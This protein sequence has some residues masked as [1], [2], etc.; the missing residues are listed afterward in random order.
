VTS[1]PDLPPASLRL[2]ID[3]DALAGNWRALNR[4]SGNAQA[5]A[6]V[7]ANAYGVGVDQ[8]MPALLKAGARSF[9]VAH[10]S[11][12]PPLLDHV[13][14]DALSVLH[15]I[16]NASEARFAQATGVRPVINSLHQA[17]IWAASGG[18]ACH[19]MIDT[20]INRLGIAP[21]EVADPVIGT[22]DIETVM[23]HLASAD[24]DTPLNA[25]QLALFHE[26]S[27]QV[28][29]QRRSLAN[30]AGIAL[31]A[32]YHFELTRPGLAIYGGVPCD[33]LSDPISQ[34]VFPQAAVLQTRWLNAGESVGYNATLTAKSR[35][36]TATISIG[37][38]DGFL[39]SWGQRGALQHG[40][41]L[42]PILGRVSMDMIVVD[43]TACEGVGEGDFLGIPYDLREAASITG[44][45]QYELLTV[46]GTRFGR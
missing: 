19:L 11:E 16:A 24:E 2:R 6:A 29:H 18:G 33:A 34:V 13:D 35:T 20:G 32:D 10:W 4:L 15:G 23:S 37:Y 14:A 43:C 17:T 7:K 46:L 41:E 42:L 45:S 31:G 39:R 22:L 44:L 36:R 30:S 40:E 21:D 1:I 3:T 27:A 28:T 26:A 8:V 38:A 9:F 12:V 5:G 25:Q